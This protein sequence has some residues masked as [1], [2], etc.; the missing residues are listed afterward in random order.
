MFY[1]RLMR[2]PQVKLYE[3]GSTFTIGKAVTLREG[4]DVTIIATGFLAWEALQA[5]QTL[6][7]RGIQARVL[8]YV[9]D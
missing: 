3:E 5:A 2:K 4:T 6:A 7:E 9:Y 1:I 8:K